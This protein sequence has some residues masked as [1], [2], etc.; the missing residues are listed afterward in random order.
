MT[1]TDPRRMRLVADAVVSGYI[2]EI[3]AQAGSGDAP[4]PARPESHRVPR[5][6]RDLAHVGRRRY[7][8]TRPA[9]SASSSSDRRRA[10]TVSA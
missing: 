6:R 9:T 5:R 7:A 10:S 3:S 1:P 2:R 8:G 4:E